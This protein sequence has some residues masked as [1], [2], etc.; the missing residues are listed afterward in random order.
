MELRDAYSALHDS[1]VK[2]YNITKGSKVKVFRKCGDYE[3]GWGTV[4]SKLMDP[5]VGQTFKVINIDSRLGIELNSATCEDD[6]WFPFFVLEPEKFDPIGIPLS[7]DY[8]AFVQRDASV[9]VGCQH[10]SFELLEQVYNA[11]NELKNPK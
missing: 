1:F 4:W 8:T 5:A 2:Q 6:F 9:K 7:P 11:A 10:I 3:M